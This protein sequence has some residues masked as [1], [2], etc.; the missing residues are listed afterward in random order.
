[1][2]SADTDSPRRYKLV[3][4]YNSYEWVAFTYDKATGIFTMYDAVS[5]TKPYVYR[6]F[7]A[8]GRLENQDVGGNP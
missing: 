5:K 4:E 8:D 7:L 1:M 3:N 6:R 2:S